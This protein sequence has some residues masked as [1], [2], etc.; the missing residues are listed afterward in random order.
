MKYFVTGATGFIGS[1]LVKKLAGN[2]HD[3]YCLVRSPEKIAE[4]QGEHI[5]PV[6]GDLDNPEALDTGTKACDVVFHLAAYAKPWSADKGLSY[7]IN[8]NG[9]L[10]LLEFSK[11]NR[12]KKF[13]F[14]SSAAVMGPSG[15]N[16]VLDESFVRIIPFFNDYES[17]KA[18]AEEYVLEY[19]EK[20]LHVVIVN[21]SRVFGPGP[22]N[23]SNSVTKIISLYRKGTW[24]IIPGDGTKIG[25]YV[26]IDDVVDG[27]LKA[28]ESGR[29]GE[30]YLL[31]GENLTFNQF[32]GVLATITGKRR[33][34]V[35]FPVWM[36]L[37][38]AKCMEFQAPYTGIPPLIT[39]PWIRKYLNHW[40]LS[41]S[42]A[43]REL[44]YRITPFSEG[45][46]K[47]IAW[48]KNRK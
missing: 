39:P 36:M 44:N 28:A 19:A 33:L 9:T 3:V 6:P 13:I 32:F 2:G 38:L 47:T 24:R 30:R 43:A 7:R 1:R 37:G 27:H 26:Y 16:R 11:R 29:N 21:P 46:E 23:E 20:G 34:L 25:N 14:T 31:G 41:S 35:H 22:V 17:E 10:N 18:I 12:V 5:Y 15:E 48:L 8:V 4:I 42:K 45:V 40:N